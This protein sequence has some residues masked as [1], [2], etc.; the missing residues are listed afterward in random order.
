MAGQASAPSACYAGYHRLTNGSR[1]ANPE[2][3]VKSNVPD[4]P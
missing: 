4:F 2:F 1:Y 3:I